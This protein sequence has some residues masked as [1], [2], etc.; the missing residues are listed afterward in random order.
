MFG[1][2]HWANSSSVDSEIATLIEVFSKPAFSYLEY[3]FAVNLIARSF[4]LSHIADSPALAAR[5]MPSF[6][7]S[8][9]P[10]KEQ[11]TGAIFCSMN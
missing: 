4:G 3:H 9:E 5:S 2:Y 10:F 11:Q 6:S 1:A 7:P 8:Q